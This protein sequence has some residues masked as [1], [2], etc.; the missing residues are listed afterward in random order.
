MHV[1]ILQIVACNLLAEHG[2]NIENRLFSNV[3]L[4]RKKIAEINEREK[5]DQKDRNI[6]T[7]IASS[8]LHILYWRVH[9]VHGGWH[10]FPR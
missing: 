9:I 6:G 7:S 1:D 4:E 3:L 5:E 2:V 8:A 10:M